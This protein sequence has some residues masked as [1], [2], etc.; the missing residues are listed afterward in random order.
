MCVRGVHTNICVK[1]EVKANKHKWL[2]GTEDQGPYTQF[3]ARAVIDL[4]KK[5]Y[6]GTGNLP[7][8]GNETDNRSSED[9]I[10]V[11]DSVWF[12]GLEVSGGQL[13]EST[14]K[15][16]LPKITLMYSTNPKLVLIMKVLREVGQIS[17][18]FSS[19]WQK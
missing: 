11:I 19:K 8:K 3:L 10:W 15:Y 6:N 1:V 18:L 14:R 9:S 17:A 5:S 4:S 2:I 13:L 7:K 16:S 12:P